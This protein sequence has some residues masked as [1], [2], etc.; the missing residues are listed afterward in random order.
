[1]DRGTRR[2]S[3]RHPT[4]LNPITRLLCTR[5]VGGPLLLWDALEHDIGAT[6]T[7]F[8]I[9]N[10]SCDSG[11]RSTGA[12]RTLLFLSLKNERAF[13]AI[14]HRLVRAKRSAK[15][16]Q[17]RHRSFRAGWSWLRG[18]ALAG[19]PQAAC[20]ILH[21]ALR[22]ATGRVAPRSTD[23]L[24]LRAAVHRACRGCGAATRANPKRE[25]KIG[26]PGRSCTQCLY[27]YRHKRLFHVT[28]TNLRLRLGVSACEWGRIGHEVRASV[29]VWRAGLYGCTMYPYYATEACIEDARRRRRKRLRR[30]KWLRQA[31]YDHLPSKPTAVP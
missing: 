10:C 4:T 16:V 8:L 31:V 3:P 15:C 18:L 27:N 6:I 14:Y 21:A 25:V 24:V 2:T 28:T 26:A 19:P 22:A 13:V 9:S 11:T 23:A 17:K 20:V 5:G 30:R 12:L 1:M 29:G 7:A